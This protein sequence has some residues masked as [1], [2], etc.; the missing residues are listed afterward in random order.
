[1]IV[2][3]FTVVSQLLALYLTA[4][5]RSWFVEGKPQAS[6]LR[7]GFKNLREDVRK[8]KVNRDTR[9]MCQLTDILANVGVEDF[10]QVHLLLAFES[11]L[12]VILRL[13]PEL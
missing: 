12:F 4:E 7:T 2:T 13:H 5:V 3:G 11:G 6:I 1:M 8:L 9:L 10:G